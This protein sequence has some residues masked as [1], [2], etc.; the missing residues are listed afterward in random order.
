MWW[1]RHCDIS[2]K[3]V[4][5]IPDGVIGIFLWR[6]PSGCTVAL[7]WI[8]PLAEMSSR[9]ISCGVKA[10]DVYCWQPYHLHVLIVMNSG[11]LDLMVPSG[12]VQV[13][14]RIALPFLLKLCMLIGYVRCWY[15]QSDSPCFIFDI[16][17][18]M[19]SIFI[20]CFTPTLDSNWH[21]II[22]TLIFL[23]SNRYSFSIC[24]SAWFI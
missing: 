6:N 19:W 4:G 10:A 15:S 9:N 20:L 17:Y 22:G 16:Y 8:H 7:G 24:L 3:V 13:C 14:N 23:L 18:I 5:L 12:P 21:N 1:L 2:R 11:S